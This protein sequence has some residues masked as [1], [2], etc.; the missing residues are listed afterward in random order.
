MEKTHDILEIPVS[1]PDDEIMIDR[2]KLNPGKVGKIW[3]KMCR[4]LI[5]TDAIPVIQIH[6]ERARIC[7]ESLEILF[8][9]ARKSDYELV[10]LKNIAQGKYKPNECIAI[11][12]DI[13]Y[14]RISDIRHVGKKD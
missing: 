1:L 7:N 12:G 14:I 11:S 4:S 13:D 6:P 8:D 2:L 3:V 10:A 9:W 5:K